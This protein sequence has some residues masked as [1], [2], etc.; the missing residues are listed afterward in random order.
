MMT[1]QTLLST[2]IAV[3]VLGMML[4]SL[5]HNGL[6]QL[7]LPRDNGGAYIRRTVAV[8]SF[9]ALIHLLIPAFG[10]KDGASLC[11]THAT[12]MMI[13]VLVQVRFESGTWKSPEELLQETLGGHKS[14]SDVAINGGAVMT[15]N[16][17]HASGVRPIV[18]TKGTSPGGAFGARTSSI[19]SARIPLE[20]GGMMGGSTTG[21]STKERLSMIAKR[22]KAGMRSRL[23]AMPA[24]SANTR[25]VAVG[26][27]APPPEGLE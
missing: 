26:V 6:E 13:S 12:F 21:Q 18:T 11:S 14:E 4:L 15:D 20:G 27:G 25:P 7:W 2:S 23:R 22:R 5:L 19:S 9:L 24:T 10:I 1:P 16:P 17:M 8:K 3:A